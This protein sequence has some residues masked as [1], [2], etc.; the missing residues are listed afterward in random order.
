MST[1]PCSS[2]CC[3]L[4][5][6]NR[7][8]PLG[9]AH[10]LGRI[11]CTRFWI[12]SKFTFNFHLNYKLHLNHKGWTYQNKLSLV[13]TFIVSYPHIFLWSL[14][15][16]MSV[17]S[18]SWWN[19]WTTHVKNVLWASLWCISYASVYVWSNSW[20]THLIED[21][22]CGFVGKLLLYLSLNYWCSQWPM[23]LF[24]FLI[25]WQLRFAQISDPIDPHLHVIWRELDVSALSKLKLVENLRMLD[26]QLLSEHSNNYVWDSL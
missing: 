19:C 8:S 23:F 10:H 1:L 17:W 22:S 11:F 14:H 7:R 12:T 15:T 5:A 9:A 13:S 2:P 18:V 6:P 21:R 20:Q 26:G 3:G 24:L 4:S 16:L 25:R